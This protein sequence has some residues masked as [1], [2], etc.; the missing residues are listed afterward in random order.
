MKYRL[1]DLLACPQCKKFPLKLTV[2]DIKK[3]PEREFKI[4]KC[5]IFCAYLNK[6][7]KEVESTPCNECIKYE[8]V[9][10]LLECDNCGNWYPIY[11]EIPVMLIG[12][13]RDRKIEKEFVK[14]Y[15]DKLPQKIVDE[16][17]GGD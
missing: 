1:M 11:D 5:E 6:N 3:Y 7:I 12:D 13:L 14:K 16:V 10:G 17:L 15:K 8:I 2:Y 9:G 4:S